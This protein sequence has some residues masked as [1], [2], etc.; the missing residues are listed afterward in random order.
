MVLCAN[1]NPK[2]SLW[3]DNKTGRHYMH[4]YAQEHS[5]KVPVLK[6]N[7][8]TLVVESNYFHNVS[9]AISATQQREKNCVIYATKL[10]FLKK[11]LGLNLVQVAQY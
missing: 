7:N 4:Q 3:T 10:I 11:Y 2:K 5:Q 1:K 6:L 9:N 8:G